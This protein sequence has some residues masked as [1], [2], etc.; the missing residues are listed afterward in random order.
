VSPQIGL[1]SAH[2]YLARLGILYIETDKHE[3]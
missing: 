2:A 3:R 1:L